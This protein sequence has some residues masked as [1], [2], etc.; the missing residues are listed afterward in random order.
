MIIPE[1]TE[2]PYAVD[3]D[4]GELKAHSEKSSADV[5]WDT[6]EFLENENDF[7]L[8]SEKLEAGDYEGLSPSKSA[9]SEPESPVEE[10]S[11]SRLAF[12]AFT[13]SLVLFGLAVLYAVQSRPSSS[14]VADSETDVE[15]SVPEDQPPAQPPEERGDPLR[16]FPSIPGAVTKTPIWLKATGLPVD[17]FFRSPAWEENAAPLYLDALFEISAS[18]RVCFREF[19]VEQRLPAT[20]NRSTRFVRLFNQIKMAEETDDRDLLQTLSQFDT[21]FAKL[22]D[23]QAL[24]ECVF[25]Q[26]IDISAETP[27]ITA[28]SEAIQ[29]FSMRIRQEIGAQKLSNAIESIDVML[30]LCR[31]L[32]PRASSRTQLRILEF[33]SAVLRMIPEVLRSPELEVEHCDALVKALIRHERQAVDPFDTS[34]IADFIAFN[35]LHRDVELNAGRFAPK[36]LAEAYGAENATAGY[37]IATELLDLPGEQVLDKIKEV[38]DY[39]HQLDDESRQRN[40]ELLVEVFG[41][42]HNLRTLPLRERTT[43]AMDEEGKLRESNPLFAISG[44]YNRLADVTIHN[45]GT[46]RGLKCLVALTRW[47]LEHSQPPNNLRTLAREAGLPAIPTDPYGGGP[48]RLTRNTRKLAVYSVGVDG[49]DDGGAIAEKPGDPEDWVFEVGTIPAKTIIG[50]PKPTISSDGGF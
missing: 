26:D 18:M 32:R 23:A 36:Y 37:V 25:E 6:D 20:R 1:S 35:K 30:R 10:G 42:L 38:N 14:V 17:G 41:S 11:G 24:S 2:D 34:V 13:A 43:F 33:D 9:D 22:K 45:V 47:R 8:S 48:F 46:I 4:S 21:A 49:K 19:D 5:E 3:I 50:Q 44:P 7:E 27:H 28:A 40:R 15:E 12:Y 16:R 39:V 29:V 31:D